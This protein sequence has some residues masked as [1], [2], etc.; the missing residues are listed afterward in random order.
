ME[1]RGE[2]FPETAPAAPGR[3]TRNGIKDA[4]LAAVRETDAAREK[5]LVIQKMVVAQERHQNGEIHYHVVLLAL[6]RPFRFGPVKAALR[7]KTGLASHWSGDLTYAGGVRY[8]YEPSL[9]KP[10]KTLDPAPL[11]WALEDEHPPLAEACREPISAA[12]WQK[13]RETGRLARLEKG[14][15]EARFRD[16]DLWPVVVAQNIKALE[17]GQHRL[18]S[19]ARASGGPAMVDYIFQNWERLPGLVKRCW[20][21]EKCEDYVAYLDKTRSQ[22][23]LEQREKPCVCGGKWLPAAFKLLEQNEIDPTEFRN[24]MV[25][26]FEEGRSKGNIL[27]FAGRHGTEGKSFLL[28]PITVVFGAGR[29]FD[30]P[31]KGNFPLLGLEKCRVAVLDDWRFN[32]DVLSY[33]LQLLWFEGAPFVIARPQN[34]HSGH[35]RYDGDA[36]IFISC[37]EADLLK[38]K[39]G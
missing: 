38:V 24:A 28:K 25:R 34:E 32:E 13:G 36:P 37:L 11:R 30:N 10:I 29:V 39:K 8:V 21:V 2:L 18:M 23:I 12:G 6:D 1:I 9:T 16:V 15:A 5:P 26:A 22:L 31:Q 4:I 33:N 17:G 3:F 7:E 19:Y 20:E 27:C 14:K 35:L